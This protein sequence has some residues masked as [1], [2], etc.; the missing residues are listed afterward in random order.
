MRRV[1]FGAVF[2]VV[3]TLAALLVVASP[4]HA[5][6]GIGSVT[7]TL[8]DGCRNQSVSVEGSNPD[9]TDWDV[10]LTL[11]APSGE[12][13][14]SDWLS[15]SGSS[16]ADTATFLVCDY[17]GVGVYDVQA[18]VTW[19]DSDYNKA[20]VDEVAGSIRMVPQ[21]T[22]SYLTV[23]DATPRYNSVV[24]F[25]LRSQQLAPAGWRNDAYEYVALESNCGR[26][27]SRVR[28]SKTSTDAYGKA[29]LRYRWNTHRTCRVRTVTLPTVNS[30]V[31]RSAIVR[32]NPH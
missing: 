31:S 16:F 20:G 13:S 22:R 5:D 17:E 4:A 9:A 24:T 27:W 3:S 28:G 25:K 6:G 23:S 7:R 2:S 18:T 12:Q 29:V 11:F 1:A 8:Y 30:A 21:R 19:Y 10:D 14:S 32:V 26:S 15:G